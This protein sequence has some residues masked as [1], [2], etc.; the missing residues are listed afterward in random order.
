MKLI[1]ACLCLS[2]AAG[3]ARAAPANGFVFPDERR[4][5]KLEPIITPPVLP[6]LEH[7]ERDPTT[8]GISDRAN[9]VKP[10]FGG[11]FNV[12][13][14]GN[15]GLSASISSSASGAGLSHSASQSFSFGFNEGFSTSHS[16]SQSSSFNGFGSGFSGSQASSQAASFSGAGASVSGAS[17][18]AASLGGFGGGSQSASSAFGF[19]SLNGFQSEPTFGEGLFDIRQRGPPLLTFQDF[20][21]GRGA[22]AAAFKT[23]PG[24]KRN[25][26]DFLAV[27]VSN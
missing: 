23:K 10:K 16:A 8:L 27:L 26:D 21:G 18:S 1:C 13:P 17:S 15:G 7:L 5:R 6:V 11:G 12:R 3:L 25:R 24:P 20:I 9:Q 4:E 14:T 19:N 2:V 22:S